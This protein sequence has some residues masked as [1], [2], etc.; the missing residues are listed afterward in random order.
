[1]ICKIQVVTI[2]VDG[3]KETREITSIQR[4]DVKP[5]TLGLTLAEGKMILKDLQQVVV[6]SQVS[7]LLLPKRTCPECGEPRC[8]KGNHTLSVRTVFGR[9]TVRSPR[10]YH[11]VCR[12]HDTKTFSPLAELLPNHTL[13]ELLFLETKWASLMSYGM[14]AKLLQDVLPIEEPV[15]TFTIRQHVANVAER[16][17]EELGDEQ[18]CFVEGSQR[19]W[20]ELP[21][22]DGPLTVGIDGGYVRG[23]RKQGQFEVIAGKSLLAFKRDQE[24]KQ[25]LSGRCFAWVQT[26]D[27]KPK[28]RL[29][30]LLQSQGMQPNQQVD[31]LSDGG[32]DVRNVQLYL[33][34]QAEH[35]LD[36]F[37]L[38]TG[39][40][41]QSTTAKGLPEGI[42]EREDQYELRT[43]VFKDLER[44]KW[45]LWH[46][47]VFQALN[48]L[49]SL[50]IDL[51]AAA[52]ESKDENSPKL[53]KGIEELHTY[54]ERNQEFVPNYGERYRNGEKIASG[55]VESAINQVVS[56]RMV[57]KQQ[58][59]GA[60]VEHIF[61]CRY[62]LG[63]STKSGR[64]PSGAGIRISALKGR[65]RKRPDP[66]ESPALLLYRP[67]RVSFRCEGPESLLH[68]VLTST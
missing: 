38:T 13:P 51:D 46:G 56:K 44:I 7:S 1:M 37:H 48:E 19:G 21:S 62:E 23:Q 39:L 27:E 55:F 24:S 9:L 58:M 41:P 54:V 12:P 15:N 11:C 10:L 63:C 32:E 33:N 2:G 57:K 26:Y 22:P 28:R 47:N 4:T 6:E 65:P 60:S 35:L 49:Q 68:Q 8:S 40:T 20:D 50:E 64:I 45:Y 66:P 52:F 14:T 18:F 31:F 43:G 3:R 17:E 5:E 61:S 53:L 29:F 25:Q 36:W 42:G 34:P 67:P 16:L 59:G 30:E